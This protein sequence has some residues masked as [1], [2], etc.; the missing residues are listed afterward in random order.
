M[1]IDIVDISNIGDRA[2][3]SPK[4]YQY[5]RL[6]E[7]TR[8]A[9]EAT[10]EPAKIELD[11]AAG[12]PGALREVDAAGTTVMIEVEVVWEALG[13]PD[14]GVLSSRIFNTEAGET[15]EYYATR[16][17]GFRV[18]RIVAW[19]WDD[20]DGE[21]V[22]GTPLALDDVVTYS[23]RLILRARIPE[24]DTYLMFM[25]AEHG[26]PYVPM[27]GMSFADKKAVATIE[28]DSYD[29]AMLVAKHILS[30]GTEGREDLE[31]MQEAA[32]RLLNSKPPLED[33]KA[34]A[35]SAY[36]TKLPNDDLSGL[37]RETHQT[38][39]SRILIDASA[40]VSEII[41]SLRGRR[42]C[43]IIFLQ[44]LRSAAEPATKPAPPRGA[45]EE[46]PA[47][48][49]AVKPKGRRS[50][51]IIFCDE[52]RPAL[53][54]T[55]M[56]RREIGAPTASKDQSRFFSRAKPLFSPQAERAASSGPS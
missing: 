17:Y 42:R 32:R 46:L 30:E 31:S 24:A 34:S 53:E 7:A 41:E 29:C 11:F 26:S 5:P 19:E 38:R 22:Y 48:N 45:S 35:A 12:A 55:G 40:K 18:P 4:K 37:L 2:G 39:A 13:R 8:A 44:R 14:T 6:E 47:A 28:V 27:G 33:L 16:I 52:M 20:I 10:H 51:F 3:S 54:K 36:S 15:V 1:L 21:G 49:P 23:S 50:S 25:Y 43:H 56:S 9:L